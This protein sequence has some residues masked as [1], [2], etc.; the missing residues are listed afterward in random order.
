MKIATTLPGVAALL[1]AVI[2]T[3]PAGEKAL[4]KLIDLGAKKCIPCKKMAPIL[5]E[6]KKEYADKFI[7]E[8]LDVWQPENAEK[9]KE[10]KINLI[11]TQIFFDSNGKELWRHEG[12]LSKEA[13]LKKWAE[14]GVDT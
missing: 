13:I 7:T 9:A 8:F 5:E 4:P 14:L 12:F 10:Y 6:L 2:T 1:L 3:V 11:P